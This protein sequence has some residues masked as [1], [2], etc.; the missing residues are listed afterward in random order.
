MFQ[1]LKKS[2]RIDSSSYF[3][4]PKKPMIFM[5]ESAKKNQRSVLWPFH[6]FQNHGYIQNSLL[7]IFWELMKKL[8]IDGYILFTHSKNQPNTDASKSSDIWIKNPSMLYSWEDLL[9]RDLPN[10]W[11]YTLKAIGGGAG[12]PGLL[13]PLQNLSIKT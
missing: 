12:L 6:I 10:C 9:P 2:K 7:W 13:S 3:E 11:A 4:N 1:F 5:K 8:I